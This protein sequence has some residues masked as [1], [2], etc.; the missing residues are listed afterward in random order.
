VE[1]RGWGKKRKT[2]SKVMKVKGGLLGS[3]REKR[4]GE[5][6]VKG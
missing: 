5:G 2:K 3:G 6:V 1:A 4:K